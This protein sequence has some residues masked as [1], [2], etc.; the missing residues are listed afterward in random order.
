MI[1]LISDDSERRRQHRLC[2][3]LPNR[4]RAY[5]AESIGCFSRWRHWLYALVWSFWRRGSEA[6]WMRS[7]D[8]AY[9]ETP[10]E[11]KPFPG[12]RKAVPTS[13][14]ISSSER[15]SFEF[16]KHATE[17]QC[18]IRGSGRAQP[19]S[20]S[21]SASEDR[22]SELNKHTSGQQ[23]GNE[24][25]DTNKTKKARC[26]R[27]R[28]PSCTSRHSNFQR[29]LTRSNSARLE[30]EIEKSGSSAR[31]FPMQAVMRGIILSMT[32]TWWRCI[33]VTMKRKAASEDSESARWNE[34]WVL[35][36]PD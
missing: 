32:R 26:L 6:T 11:W 5:D 3:V 25:E 15:R 19:K 1:T 24:V 28:L 29:K 23:R 20:S 36:S 34:H 12:S 16:E 35:E 14:T 27:L 13:S 7:W 21:V 2:E 4:H 31:P 8:W 9:G 33:N 10:V 17:Q 18:G 30:A 22:G